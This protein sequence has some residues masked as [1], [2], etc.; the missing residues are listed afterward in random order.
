[1]RPTIASEEPDDN[2][3]GCRYLRDI[4]QCCVIIATLLNAGRA[5]AFQATP[6]VEGRRVPAPT[7]PKLPGV[8]E[9]VPDGIGAGAP[10][11][12]AAFFAVPPAELNAA[13]LYLDA[14][15]EFDPVMAA[16]FPANAETARRKQLAERRIQS[17]GRTYD[18]FV[19]APA[20]V[21]GEAIDRLVADLEDGMRKVEEAQRRP[22]CVFQTGLGPGI[23][24]VH[25]QA[26]GQVARLA[27][28]RTRRHLDRGDPERPLLDLAIVLRLARDLRPRGP[29]FCQLAATNL[30][31][32]C[33]R[34]I[35]LLLLASPAFSEP[36]ARRLLKAW[37]DHEATSIDGYREGLEAEY[38]TLRKILAEML[39]DP[40]GSIPDLLDRLL[41]SRKEGPREKPRAYA[42]IVRH[43]IE[44]MTGDQI[45]RMNSK[46]DEV[47]RDL[48]ALQDR[49]FSR[50]PH[51]PFDVKQFLDGSFYSKLPAILLPAAR[52]CGE[53]EA[54]AKA[55]VRCTT[56]LIALRMWMDRTHQVPADLDTVV[57]AAGLPK[58]PID[59]YSGEPLR[60]AIVDGKPVIYS[61]GKDGR[62][63]GGKFDSS[64]DRKPGDQT[65]RLPA[66]EKPGR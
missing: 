6:P 41:N 60:L 16:C 21:S 31:G 9:R 58:V 34:Q 20:S 39:K 1:M 2:A 33:A 64:D 3:A 45:N 24:L 47:F 22:R 54:R 62:D 12:V 44:S 42:Q 59:P 43:Q 37:A 35:T 5:A 30:T 17:V 53:A 14:L 10:F 27:V 38:V 50:W 55:Y 40:H 36:Y 51:E 15:F 19:K 61:I 46:V 29:M 57:K 52:S 32:A 13:P 26:A 49:P 7:E 8:V 66:I 63:D 48:L 18:A 4:V 65:Y 11:D 25:A 28:L 23:P 56:C